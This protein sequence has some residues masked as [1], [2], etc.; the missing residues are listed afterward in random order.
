MTVIDKEWQDGDDSAMVDEALIEVRDRLAFA[1]KNV[2]EEL[3][4]LYK[5]YEDGG[6]YSNE[7]RTFMDYFEGQVCAYE[8]AI[9]IV[10]GKE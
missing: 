7:D 3:A 6:F 10:E 2:Q 5:K 8:H 1:L 9:A 4:G